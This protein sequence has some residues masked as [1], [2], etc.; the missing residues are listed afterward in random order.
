MMMNGTID[1]YAI[2]ATI[3]Y[4]DTDEDTYGDFDD[5]TFSCLQPEHFVDNHYDCDDMDG[6]IN[7]DMTEICDAMDN[8]CDGAVDEAGSGIQR[9]YEDQDGDGFDEY[10]RQY[11]CLYTA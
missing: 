4:A 10:C 6:Q 1:E 9:W 2:D 11:L 8:D 3:W 5:W 7:P